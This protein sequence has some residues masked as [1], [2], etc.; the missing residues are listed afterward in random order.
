MDAFAE[1]MWVAWTLC[2]R[3]ETFTTDEGEQTNWSVDWGAFSAAVAARH[4]AFSEDDPA[5]VFE[6]MITV[7]NEL[8][9]PMGEVML[10]D[11]QQE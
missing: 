6:A 5:D 10:E 2:G 9:R 1:R 4:P 7:R 3:G 11:A 8:M